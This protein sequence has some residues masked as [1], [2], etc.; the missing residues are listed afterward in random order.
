MKM[1]KSEFIAKLERNELSVF[2][3]TES[4]L[5]WET[6]DKKAKKPT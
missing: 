5:V 1:V 3:N 6:F 4:Q 2:R